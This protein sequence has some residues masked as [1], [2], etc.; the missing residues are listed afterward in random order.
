LDQIIDKIKNWAYQTEDVIGI[1]IIGS[2]ARKNKP[3]DEWADLDLLLIAKN[4]EK[5]LVNTTWLLEIGNVKLTHLEQTLFGDMERRVLFQLGDDCTACLVDFV[6]IGSDFAASIKEKKL[7]PETL[8]VLN[9]GYRVLVDKGG[10]A[11]SL[12]PVGSLERRQSKKPSQDDFIN[13]ANDF[14]FHIIWSAK[15]IQRGELWSAYQCLGGY[16]K[17]QCL[18]PMIEWFMLA[19]HGW[20]YD[21]WFAGRFIEEWADPEILAA[22]KNAIPKYQKQD[23]IKATLLL[24]NLFRWLAKDTVAK[25]CYDYPDESHEWVTEWIGKCFFKKN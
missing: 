17:Q 7:S 25:L 14:L 24:L 10:F 21:V 23:M 18:L 1:I 19:K 16:L 12:P 3:A 11:E 8:A 20:D 15:K 13:C 4:F 9:L 5:Y 6:P 2:Y 22:L